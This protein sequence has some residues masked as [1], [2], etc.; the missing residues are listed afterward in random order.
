ML[1]GVT[2]DVAIAREETFGPVAPLFVFR[3]EADAIALANETEFGLAAYFCGRDIAPIWRVAEAF[4]YG[5]VGIN[6]G[7]IS[8]EVAPFGGVR[9]SS[10]GREESKRGIDDYLDIKYL[11][12]GGV[13]QSAVC[14]SST[15]RQ[16]ASREPTCDDNLTTACVVLHLRLARATESRM[17]CRR[18]NFTYCAERLVDGH[19]CVRMAVCIGIG[20][21]DA[22]ER[23][24]PNHAGTF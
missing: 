9:D 13:R 21:L 10:V 4:E 16:H 12:F 5:I 7:L 14:T 1:T 3:S 18:R 24:P 11:C 23:F 17:G 20:D 2:R 22:P 15:G 6:G 8:T 19:V